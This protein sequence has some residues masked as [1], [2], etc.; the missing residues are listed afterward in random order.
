[1]TNVYEGSPDGRQSA[2]PSLP[3]SRFRPRYRALSDIEKDLHDAIKQSAAQI[4]DLYAQVEIV[5]RMGGHAD[6]PRYTAL[7]ITA[8]ESSVMWIVKALTA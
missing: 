6:E 5:R 2:D 4:E 7:A 3:T 8:L 1:V